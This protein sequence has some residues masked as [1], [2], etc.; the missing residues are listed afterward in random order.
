MKGTHLKVSIPDSYGDGDRER[1]R[2]GLGLNAPG[3]L[4]R[5]TV[6]SVSHGVGI[7]D[8]MALREGA[9]GCSL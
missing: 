1:E 6:G 8:V 2:I 3:E 4:V 7:L 9:G 5:I